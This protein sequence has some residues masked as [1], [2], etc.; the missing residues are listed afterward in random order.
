MLGS[1]S[2]PGCSLIHASLFPRVRTAFCCLLSNSLRHLQELPSPKFFAAT[3]PRLPPAQGRRLLQD[4]SYFQLPLAIS[5]ARKEALKK[6]ELPFVCQGLLGSCMMM[7]QILFNKLLFLATCSWSCAA[8]WPLGSHGCS[9]VSQETWGNN[10]ELVLSL[11]W[12]SS[13]FR[14]WGTSL[15]KSQGEAACLVIVH[16]TSLALSEKRLQLER[17]TVLKASS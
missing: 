7:Q 6:S 11:G 10:P 13:L 3:S 17:I 8:G 4:T 14:S 12:A 15:Q 16:S 1:L 5:D 2:P 9:E